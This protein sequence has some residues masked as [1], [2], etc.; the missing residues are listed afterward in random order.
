[1]QFTNPMYY[2]L[3]LVIAHYLTVI[4][5]NKYFKVKSHTKI[6][7]LSQYQRKHLKLCINI[8][9]KLRLLSCSIYPF[10]QMRKNDKGRNVQNAG[11][12]ERLVSVQNIANDDIPVNQHIL[13]VDNL[14]VIKK[15][16][17]LPIFFF[18]LSLGTGVNY[19]FWCWF[20]N[21]NIQ[22]TCHTVSSHTCTPKV[23]QHAHIECLM[24]NSKRTKL[25]KL[26]SVYSLAAFHTSFLK[27]IMVWQSHY[28]CHLL[29]AS[30]CHLQLCEWNLI[31]SLRADSSGTRP[32]LP[33]RSTLLS[34][35]KSGW[36][37]EPGTSCCLIM[38]HKALVTGIC[39]F[40][41][42]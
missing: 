4:F 6:L 31:C 30:H 1:M 19:P 28:T 14:K 21:Y 33:H 24:P 36:D 32:P 20:L 42:S 9:E 16:N 40:F 22:F 10:Q 18:F 29:N 38:L 7:S 39:T 27:P 2:I 25:L 12:W 35:S 3:C 34:P 26:E 23:L 5:P 8:L 13:L 41:F 11:L 17:H 37:P 15:R